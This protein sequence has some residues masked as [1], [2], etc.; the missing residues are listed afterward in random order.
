MLHLKRFIWV[1]KLIK[2][3]D[4]VRFESVIEIQKEWLASNVVLQKAKEYRLFSVV[5]HLG[6]FAHRGHYVNYAMDSEDEWKKFDDTK[7]SSRDLDTMQET[8]QAYILFYELIY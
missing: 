7:V 3:K 8:V 5:E 2:M 1:D 4:Y 6:E